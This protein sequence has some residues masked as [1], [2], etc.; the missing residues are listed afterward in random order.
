MRIY[1]I[2]IF[3]EISLRQPV[4]GKLVLPKKKTHFIPSLCFQ[5]REE[6]TRSGLELLLIIAFSFLEEEHA[7]III[8]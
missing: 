4:V 5:N 2:T 6:V 1:S 8:A 7:L 3:Y